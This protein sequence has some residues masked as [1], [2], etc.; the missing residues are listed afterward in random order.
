MR[1]LVDA[2]SVVYKASFLAEYEQIYKSIAQ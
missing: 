1:F 2:I